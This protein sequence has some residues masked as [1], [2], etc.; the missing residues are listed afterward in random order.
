MAEIEY[1]IA[2][3]QEFNLSRKQTGDVNDQFHSVKV[4]LESWIMS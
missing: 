2:L 3:L 4:E 1:K